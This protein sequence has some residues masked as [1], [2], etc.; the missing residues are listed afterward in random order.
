MASLEREG[1][2]LELTSVSP[3]PC[4]ALHK[5]FIQSGASSKPEKRAHA[6][7]SAVLGLSSRAAAAAVTYACW[8][9]LAKPSAVDFNPLVT[10]RETPTS[11][12]FASIRQAGTGQFSHDTIT[13]PTSAMNT[14]KIHDT[15]I[16]YQIDKHT[17]HCVLESRKTSQSWL[18]YS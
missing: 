5:L 12:F 1:G 3:P 9:R 13:A 4:R 11:S 2:L 18:E 15:V 8:L 7:C 6:K 17:R 10:K 14:F 16:V